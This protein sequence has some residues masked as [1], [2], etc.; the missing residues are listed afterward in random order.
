MGVKFKDI[1][2][3]ESIKFE[4]LKGKTVA[5]DAANI[6]Y[7]F[8]SI[9]RQADGTPLM[10]HRGKVT[11]HFSGI[12]YRTTSLIER[13]IKPFY[14]FDGAPSVLKKSTQMK[15]SEVKEESRKKWREA[16]ENGNIEEARKY[17]GRTSRMSTEI[18]EGSK[19][20]LELMGIPYIQAKG[21]GEAQASYMVEKGDAWCVGSQDYDCILFGATRM[22]KNLTIT[23]GKANLELIKLQKV[24]EEINLSREQLIDV[25]ILVG[26]DFNEGVKGIGA[27][28]GINLIKKHGDVFKVLDELNLELEVDP[29]DLREIFLEHDFLS[30]YQLKWE[31][32]DREAI[33]EFLAGEHDFSE[34][35]L[36]NALDKLKKLDSNQ[37]S[38]EKWF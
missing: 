9:I 14:V 11:S 35:R 12:L 22:V 24:L 2:N 7:Q 10:D 38:L 6:I 26:T 5:L 31:N 27:K 18:I 8:L 3:P 21:E 30:D 13:E 25:A 20:L 37:S 4:D 23:R 29:E 16:L 33:V 1:V 34:D 32:P 36:V 28:K 17:A 19:K 15:R